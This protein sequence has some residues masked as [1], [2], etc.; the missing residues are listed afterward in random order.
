MLIRPFPYTWGEG[1]G[2]GRGS[3]PSAGG[4]KYEYVYLQVPVRIPFALLNM[5]YLRD[6][7][8]STT[9]SCFPWFLFFLMYS[10]SFYQNAHSGQDMVAKIWGE[11]N[12]NHCMLPTVCGYVN[13]ARAHLFQSS[14]EIIDIQQ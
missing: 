13:S 6:F 5:L 10:L 11:K 9:F 1:M 2:G 7:I 4:S 8:L 3:F 12:Y 14:I